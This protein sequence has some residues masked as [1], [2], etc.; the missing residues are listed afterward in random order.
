[1]S[2]LSPMALMLFASI[3]MIGYYHM[4]ARIA[5][6][7]ALGALLV[8]IGALLTKQSAIAEQSSVV[9][10]LSLVVGVVGELITP[11]FARLHRG[12][13][14]VITPKESFIQEYRQALSEYAW[15]SGVAIGILIVVLC[16][17]Q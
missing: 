7:V 9:V 4:D 5:F 8:T 15:M 16:V 17:F 14:P 1:M 6:G 13:T 10:Y 2:I 3:F 12:A 11:L